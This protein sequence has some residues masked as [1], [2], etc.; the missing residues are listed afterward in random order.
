MHVVYMFLKSKCFSIGP[1]M[2]HNLNYL[3]VWLTVN[4]EFII[5]YFI[6]FDREIIKIPLLKVWSMLI[7][8]PKTCWSCSIILNY[9][10]SIHIARL[11]CCLWCCVKIL[12]ACNFFLI[13]YPYTV[14]EVYWDL[15]NLCIYMILK[16]F[17]S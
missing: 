14:V 4:W 3:L 5:E 1:V 7:K 13:R 11:K 8:S 12:T 17:Y 9:D 10:I 2:K 6:M 16:K 15:K